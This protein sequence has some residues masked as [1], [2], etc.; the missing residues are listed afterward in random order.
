M[1]GL[2]WCRREGVLVGQCLRG[3]RREAIRIAGIAERSGETR[4]REEVFNA[5]GSK[6]AKRGHEGRRLHRQNAVAQRG[7]GLEV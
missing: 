1:R 4:G 7:F 3:E 5:K 6:S 2:R